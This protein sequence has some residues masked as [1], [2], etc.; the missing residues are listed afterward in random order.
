[1]CCQFL[2]IV[3]FLLPLQYSLTFIYLN[4]YLLLRLGINVGYQQIIFWQ[5]QVKFNVM[6][7]MFQLVLHDVSSL[8]QLFAGRLGH[9]ILIQCQ[10]VFALTP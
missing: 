3:H 1:M 6:M 9:V 5:E 7:I 4:H 10:P 8:Q 2:W